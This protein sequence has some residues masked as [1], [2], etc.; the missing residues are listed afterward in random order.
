M[1]LALSVK[2]GCSCLSHN[3][4]GSGISIARKGQV[5]LLARKADP[6][7]TL[8][9]RKRFVSEMNRRFEELKR[10]IK[11]SIVEL[12]C[13]GLDDKRIYSLAPT[14]AKQFAF[15]RD[16]RKVEEFMK[17]LDVQNQEFILSEG[18]KGIKLIRRPGTFRGIDSH[19]TDVYVHHAY[20][21]GMTRARAEMRKRGVDVPSFGDKPGQ[22]NIQAAF[23]QPFHADR[24]GVLYT[25]TYNELKGITNAMDQQISRVLADGMAAGL[26]PL[27][28]A[29]TITDR[30]DKIGRTRA[31]TLART[32]IIRAHHHANIAEYERAG[33]EG[34]VVQA[35]WHTADVGVCP[36][37][38]PLNGRKYS[39]E[40]IKPLIPKH[41]N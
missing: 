38:A 35:E 4:G 37:C 39:L 9:L 6:T 17:W 15:V 22:D 23:N 24:V 28:I 7:Y 1:K 40:E 18:T 26:N 31:R 3:S 29:K 27:D 20:Q 8:T 34:V 36:I 10:V 33:I 12:D 11:K 16:D 41:P 2:S 32:E 30:V 19:W 14:T 21:K 25:R 5:L 13:F